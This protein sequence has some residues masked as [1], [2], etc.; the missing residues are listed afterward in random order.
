M[1][2]QPVTV[3]LGAASLCVALVGAC[4]GRTTDE[5]IDAAAYCRGISD[6]AEV[7]LDAAARTRAR[8][9]HRRMAEGGGQPQEEQREVRGLLGD[10]QVARQ[11]AGAD[12]ICVKAVC[13][14][15]LDVSLLIGKGDMTAALDQV[16]ALL[17][18]LRGSG[19]CAGNSRP[20]RS[21]FCEGVVRDLLH[22]RAVEASRLAEMRATRDAMPADKVVGRA[23]LTETLIELE[24]EA[25]LAVTFSSMI[26][27]TCVAPARRLACHQLLNAAG[28]DGPTLAA[29]LSA[30]DLAVKGEP[31][32]GAHLP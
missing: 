3:V 4:G 14:A 27:D 26:V 32:D 24:R 28:D 30:I 12:E 16:Q 21:A 19:A 11:F 7:R 13:P 15:T 17:A 18:G 6:V 1:T 20:R 10:Y 22:V 23:G 9:A 5:R 31:C 29:K 25:R 2:V 8:S